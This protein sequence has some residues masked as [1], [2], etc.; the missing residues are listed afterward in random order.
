MYGK[1]QAQAYQLEKDG[2]AMIFAPSRALN[3]STY[4][5]DVA[6]Q[7]ELYQLGLDDF[8]ADKEALHAFLA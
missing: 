7:E 4:T 1:C 3:I 8:E 6:V 5:M 2:K